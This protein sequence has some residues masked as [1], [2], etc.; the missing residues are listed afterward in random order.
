MVKPNFR[1]LVGFHCSL[2]WAG[3]FAICGSSA[4]QRRGAALRLRAGLTCAAPANK[5]IARRTETEND[6]TEWDINRY[7]AIPRFR[8]SRPR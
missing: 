4:A 5:I 7:T 1:L 2:G 6:S 8:A 3:A